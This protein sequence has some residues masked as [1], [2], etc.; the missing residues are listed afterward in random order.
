MPTIISNARIQSTKKLK[1]VSGRAASLESEILLAHAVGLTHEELLTHDDR[2]VPARALMR[3]R[4][5]LKR[6]LRHEPVAYVTG[7]KEFFGLDFFVNKH[8]LIPRPETETLVELALLIITPPTPSYLKR[9][10]KILPL[11]QRGEKI[12]PL[13]TRRETISPLRLRGGQE[14]LRPIVID[15][16]TGSGAIA[17]AVAKSNPNL[18]IIA[19][20]TSKEALA[21]AKR[22]A[23]CNDVASQ[24]IFR[25][26]NLLDPVR[27]NELGGGPIII[28]ANLPYLTTAQ[29]RKTAPDVRKY[30]PRSALDGGRDGLKFYD[31]LFDRIAS[32]F[33]RSSTSV[34]ILCE[35]DPAQKK[36]I[37]A[38]TK[39]HFPKAK[40]EIKN[41]LAG[42]ARV[43]IIA[44]PT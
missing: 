33:Y 15:V 38:L 42:L 17:V 31:A 11:V 28:T 21:V 36:K 35:I 24:I 2:P 20:D 30:E 18:T 43:A 10:E 27:M 23:I 8:V 44:N 1:R 41:D 32:R 7:H 14:G 34:T 40:I 22:N 5:F 9:G 25:R 37:A 19:T 12:L 4:Q 29:W 6:R 3:F 13:G 39:H 16:G 26:G